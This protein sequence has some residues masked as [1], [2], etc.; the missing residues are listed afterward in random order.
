MSGLLGAAILVPFV[1]GFLLLVLRRLPRGL[2][3]AVS[4]LASAATLALVVMLW[5]R[6]GTGSHGLW[7]MGI[8]RVLPSPLMVVDGIGL[9]LATVFAFVW[10]LVTLYSTGYL[11]GYD[12]Q[13]DYFGFLLMMLGAMVGLCFA[14]NMLMIYLF[15]ELAGI[16]TWR[17]VA[18]YRSDREVAAARKT[19]LITFAG[20]VL[21]LVGFAV[22]FVEH[23]TFSPDRLSGPGMNPWALFLILAGIVTKSASVPMYVWLPDAHTSAPSPMSAVLSGIVAKIGLIA[24]IRIFI[25]SPL[26]PPESW[27]LIVGGIGVAGSLLAAGGALYARDYKRVLAYSTV[28]QLG[29]IFIGFAFAATFGLHAGIIYLVAHCLAKAG[30]FLAMG[31]VEKTTGRRD[32]TELG[33]LARTMPVTAAATAVMMLSIIGLPPLLGFWGKFYV[34]LAAVRGEALVIAIAAL[35]AAVMTALYMVRLYRMFTGE[36]R[37]GVAGREVGL[38]S[39]VVAVLALATLALGVA[40]PWLSGYL[41][42]ALAATGM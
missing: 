2:R 15:W 5:S 35:V 21:M 28:S 27:P 40:Y 41:D 20:S 26:A 36:P 8:L 9:L 34:I 32:L 18:F 39:S 14:R 16:A 4:V 22:V 7:L 13:D 24:Y 38:L 12:Y 1:T 37:E 3:N 42:A 33:G 31:V 25:Q 10:L 17:L 29:Y 23:Q 6:A 19:L 30:L 11:K